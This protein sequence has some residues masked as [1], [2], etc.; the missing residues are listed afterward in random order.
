MSRRYLSQ[1]SF[2]EGYHTLD[3]EPR[4]FVVQLA[5]DRQFQ[6][7]RIRNTVVPSH[8]ISASELEDCIG[9]AHSL[10][11]MAYFF[12]LTTAPN[13]ICTDLHEAQP[14]RG[15]SRSDAQS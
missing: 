6:A 11:I 1:P 8:Q 3:A 15:R 7:E 9:R 13:V 12:E 2:A 4:P 5:G 14:R 10:T